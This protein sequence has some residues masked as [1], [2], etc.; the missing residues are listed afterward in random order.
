MREHANQR[1]LLESKSSKRVRRL[2]K[3][4]VTSPA[5]KK[6]IKRLLGM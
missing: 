2:A 5:D 4:V 3:D 1:H 6:R